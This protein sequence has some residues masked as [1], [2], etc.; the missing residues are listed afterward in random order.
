M[1]HSLF[2]VTVLAAA[3]ASSGT[4][5]P[6]TVTALRAPGDGSAPVRYDGSADEVDVATP[7]VANARIDVNG[8]IDEPAWQ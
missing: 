5:V 6:D 1:I 4:A 2:Q 8:R 7:A 3:V